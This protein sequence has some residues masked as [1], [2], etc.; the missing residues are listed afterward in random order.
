MSPD[1][2]PIDNESSVLDKH[3]T[4]IEYLR[5]ERYLSW[6]KISEDIN[7]EF[8]Y[9]LSKHYYERLYLKIMSMRRATTRLIISSLWTKQG[10]TG[11]R[12]K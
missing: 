9:S 5:C 8:G 2:F 1:L 4:E 7:A 12:A 6:R 10:L 3:M 11:L